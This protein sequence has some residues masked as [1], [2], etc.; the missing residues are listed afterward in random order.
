MGNTELQ[1]ETY[2]LAIVLLDEFE[3][4]SRN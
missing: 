1:E 3:E 2:V 4:M